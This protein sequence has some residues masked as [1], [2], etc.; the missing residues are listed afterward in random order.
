MNDFFYAFVSLFTEMAPYLLLGFLLAGVLHVWVPK[1]L[2]IP[3]ISKAKFK[4]VVWPA[5]FGIP[6]PFCSCGVIPTALSFR[7]DCASPGASLSFLISTSATGAYTILATYSI[8]FI[9]STI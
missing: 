4:S 8:Q 3:K 5:L 1:S 9:L 2:Y 6:L 7:Q